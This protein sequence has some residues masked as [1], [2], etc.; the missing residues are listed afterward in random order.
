MKDI[1]LEK[2]G[3]RLVKFESKP[4]DELL[5][6]KTKKYLY[7]IGFPCGSSIGAIELDLNGELI[8]LPEN[9]IQINSSTEDGLIF[10]IDPEKNDALY[11]YSHY[12]KRSFFVNSS[13]ENYVYCLYELESFH[14][15]I[16]SERVFGETDEDGISEKYA[17]YLEE[18]FKAIEE[19][20]AYWGG[21]VEDIESGLRL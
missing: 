1:I 12:W 21:E 11:Y 13:L 18:R 4:F 20:L 15:N 2:L 16:Y 9:R 6:E 14:E 5:Q 19:N 7:E 10:Y 3:S 8:L 17:H